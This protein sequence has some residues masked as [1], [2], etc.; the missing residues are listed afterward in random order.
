MSGLTNPALK[1]ALLGRWE[2]ADSPEAPLTVGQR[3]AINE[4]GRWC[5]SRQ[6][7]S[8]VSYKII[9]ISSKRIPC[10][11]SNLRFGPGP[12]AQT[13]RCK[14]DKEKT[15]VPILLTFYSI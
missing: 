8:D 12:R 4:L 15:K 2:R 7:P 3:D 14:R 13:G 10:S 1:A 11:V 5:E 6:L 9:T